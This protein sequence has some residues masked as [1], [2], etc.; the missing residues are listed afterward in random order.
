[1]VSVRLGDGRPVKQGDK[2]IVWEEETDPLLTK[3]GVTGLGAVGELEV[4]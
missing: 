3:F 4:A 1:M 2:F